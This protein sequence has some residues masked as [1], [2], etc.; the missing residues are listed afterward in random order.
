MARKRAIG[1]KRWRKAGSGL[2]VI[3]KQILNPDLVLAVGLV[4]QTSAIDPH[5]RTQI[6][7]TSAAF[8]SIDVPVAA[9]AFSLRNACTVSGR[10][11]TA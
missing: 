11:S 8:A 3:R 2:V 5:L 9:T 7:R 6:T 1:G 10:T 4:A